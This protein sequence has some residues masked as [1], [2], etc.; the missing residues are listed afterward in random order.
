MKT[1]LTFLLA[2]VAAALL[3]IVGPE[4]DAQTLATND[5]VTQLGQRERAE[6]A[7]RHICG[8]NAAFELIGN[9]LQCFTTRSE[10]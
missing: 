8:P 10:K 2:I 5:A 1:T 9:D 3:S 4:L 6:I 7:A